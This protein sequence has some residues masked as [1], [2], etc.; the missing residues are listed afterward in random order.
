MMFS[1]YVNLN[2]SDNIS[3]ISSWSKILRQN[4][5][6]E[7]PQVTNVIIDALQYNCTDVK[8]PKCFLE[9]SQDT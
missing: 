8:Q 4:L 9:L 5:I 7:I 6:S 3:G 2:K 1:S